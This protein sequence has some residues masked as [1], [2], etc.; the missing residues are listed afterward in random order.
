MSD[1][2][3][4]ESKTVKKITSLHAISHDKD[5]DGLNSAAIV[6]RYAKSKGL[7]F[8]VTLTDYGGFEPVFS[9]IASRRDT[10][11]VVSDLGIDDTTVDIVL[12]DCMVRSSPMV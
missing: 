3:E 11:I 7:D 6:W 1:T 9:S 2:R 4:S 5:V 12:Q 10:L 8:S